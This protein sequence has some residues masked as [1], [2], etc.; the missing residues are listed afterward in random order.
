MI[1]IS[2]MNLADAIAMLEARAGVMMP[3]HDKDWYTL[4]QYVREA[5]RELFTKTH[6][7]KEWAYQKSIDVQHLTVLPT[8]YVKPTRVVARDPASN[9][10]TYPWVEAR[11]VDPREWRQIT[12]TARRPSFVGF[13]VDNP[14][15]MVWANNDATATW[16]NQNVAIWVWP[17]DRLARLDY[18]ANYSD[19]NL[20]EAADPLLVPAELETL[21][22]EM[23]LMRLLMDS[24]DPQRAI[25]LSKKVMET[26]QSFRSAY[27]TTL[28]T[29]PLN[30]EALPTPTPAQVTT[31]QGG[32]V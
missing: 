18:L 9:I 17:N 22:I 11:K 2:G 19:A 4:A 12:S 14:V 23:A 32:S 29:E 15:Y 7:Y 10:A 27:V 31:T 8:D 3:A 25:D 24:P 6:S 5:R 21:V 28:V 1:A 26:L 13:S 16:S 30:S 20:S